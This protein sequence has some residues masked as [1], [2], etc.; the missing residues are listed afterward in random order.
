MSEKPAINAPAAALLFEIID[1]P[2]E[3]AVT[4]VV[5][6]E[7][8]TGLLGTMAS[9]TAEQASHVPAPGRKS[10][11]AHAQHLRFALELAAERLRGKTPD[12]DWDS[13][14]EPAVVTPAEWKQLQDRI[15]AAS[16]TVRKLIADG[17]AWDNM[18]LQG[19]VATVAHTAYHLGA[20]RQLLPTS[21][22]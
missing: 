17:D 18:M 16:A 11:A 13:S 5:S 10:A 20:M 3:P 15:R 21:P 14:W 12:A 6:N 2:A 7:R 4:W 8:N 1:G 9:M 19:I 22:S